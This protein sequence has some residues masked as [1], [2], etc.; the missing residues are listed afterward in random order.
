MT[1]AKG[2]NQEYGSY[3]L[4]EIT[5]RVPQAEI[6][7]AVWQ[8]RAKRLQQ[9]RNQWDAVGESDAHPFRG[10]QAHGVEKW[11]APLI[12]SEKQ[13]TGNVTGGVPGNKV[14]TLTSQKTGRVKIQDHSCREKQCQGVGYAGR[15]P[16][17]EHRIIC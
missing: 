13:P 8:Q 12:L 11:K 1:C 4:Q 16:A 3:G 14:R 7:E 2:A 5:E 10:V 17:R 15:E 6:M 9:E